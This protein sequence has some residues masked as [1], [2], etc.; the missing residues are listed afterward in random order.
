MGTNESTCSATRELPPR[1]DVG[2][3]WLWQEP[4]TA[5]TQGG[6]VANAGGHATAAAT[7][8]EKARPPNDLMGGAAPA[9]RDYKKP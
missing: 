4:Y 6:A 1:D 8:A 2:T 3:G 5:K 9:R 7:R